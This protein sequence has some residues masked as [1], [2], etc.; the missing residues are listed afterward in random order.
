MHPARC[1]AG[2]RDHFFATITLSAVCLFLRG[3]CDSRRAHAQ[4]GD[5]ALP[6]HST[7]W[8]SARHV[9]GVVSPR[10]HGQEGMPPMKDLGLGSKSKK[11]GHA[12]HAPCHISLSD[13]AV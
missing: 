3:D 10:L 11:D 6:L 4:G 9:L 7:S 8:R 13:S 12:P 2:R 5:T 1:A